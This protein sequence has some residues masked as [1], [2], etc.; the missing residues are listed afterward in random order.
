MTI[1][2]KQVKRI[3]QTRQ[4]MIL[5][6][7]ILTGFSTLSKAQNE[8]NTSILVE[9]GSASITSRELEKT[10]ASSPF[11]VQFNTMSRDEQASLRGV[12][13]KRMV[14]SRLLKLDAEEKNIADNK[15][16]QSDIARFRKSLLYKR[17]MYGLR[18]SV[19]LTKDSLK[20]LMQ[21]FKDKPDALA[22]ASATSLTQ[23][24][25]AVR[26]LAIQH[27]RESYKVRTFEERIKRGMP[28][29][30]IL[31]QGNNIDITYGDLL[32]GYDLRTAPD[33]NWIKERLYQQAEV[34]LV[35]NDALRQGIDVTRQVDNYKRERLP[36][37]LRTQLEKKWI[38]TDHTLKDYYNTHPQIGVIAPRW[39]I[40]QLVVATKA[41]AER[42]RNAMVNGAS[43][44]KMAG[45]YSIDPYGR[46]KNGDMGWLRKNKGHPALLKAIE[47][48]QE[49]QF[50]PVVKTSKG[51]HI[52]TVLD[53]RESKRLA[54]NTII[55]K[56]RQTFIDE[57][58]IE[59]L[60]IL[61]R[62]YKVVWKVL[63]Q[64]GF[65]KNDKS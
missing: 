10:L 50:S 26:V 9:V 43:L 17:Y 59:Y 29:T 22:A 21:E 3:G 53:K 65:P 24:Y 32:E 11:G 63:Q 40:G 58:M 1:L 20:Q 15:A 64:R 27:L 48:L 38:S 45:R 16:F 57:K 8:P 41:E 2:F 39:H 25:R 6:V 13:L 33:V 7:L 18:D 31:L 54:Y 19:T 61:Q 28:R 30:T 62:K 47:N 34:E 4:R 42:L 56:V 35:A 44:F 12:I 36:A 60:K 49:G 14:A 55:D 51:Y 46:A 23:R 52:I 37:M 5:A